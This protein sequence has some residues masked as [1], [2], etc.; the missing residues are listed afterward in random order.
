MRALPF[1][2]TLLIAAAA[3]VQA[4]SAADDACRFRGHVYE[5][6]P[7]A[8]ATR[9]DMEALLPKRVRLQ[10]AADET[11]QCL[12]LKYGIEASAFR[13]PFIGDPMVTDPDDQELVIRVTTLLKRQMRQHN[14]AMVE[15]VRR[16][17]AAL[18]RASV[19]VAPSGR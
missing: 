6:P 10:A 12:R 14:E 13:R 19:A 4:L 9:A 11:M 1:L 8:A 15:V 18:A 2:S 7:P 16:E 3:P 17:Q 5:V